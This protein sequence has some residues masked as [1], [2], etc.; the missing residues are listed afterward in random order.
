MLDGNAD[1]SLS[2]P[3][4]ITE[5]VFPLQALVVGDVNGDGSTDLVF[6]TGNNSSPNTVGVLLEHGQQC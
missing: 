2:P 1:G 6:V 5:A 4:N 3:V